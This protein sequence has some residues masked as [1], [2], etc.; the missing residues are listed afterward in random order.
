MVGRGKQAVTRK[1]RA[2]KIQ[3]PKPVRK[4]NKQKKI[5]SVATTVPVQYRI[6]HRAAELKIRRKV[7]G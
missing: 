1:R 7:R 2:T 3:E 6:I 5:V 4:R